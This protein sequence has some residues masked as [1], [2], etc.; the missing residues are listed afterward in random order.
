[1]KEVSEKADIFIILS[2]S[3]GYDI[4]IPQSYR[5]I[6]GHS[7]YSVVRFGFLFP[8]HSLFVFSVL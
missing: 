4:I 6:R 1:M 7:F 5:Y 3:E 8:I 2:L